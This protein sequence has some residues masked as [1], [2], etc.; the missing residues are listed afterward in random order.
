M[1]KQGEKYLKKIQNKLNPIQE[2]FNGILGSNPAMDA[3]LAADSK[4][5]DANVSRLNNNIAQYG[6]EYVDLKEKTEYYLNNASSN[7]NTEK[8]YNVFINKSL[9]QDKITGTNKLG[10]VKTDSVQDSLTNITEA[11]GFKAAYPANFK[12]YSA[13]ETAC[14]LWAADSSSPA[15][16]LNRDT[17]GV[18]QCYTGSGVAETRLEQYTIPKNL[19]T[20]AKGTESE[21]AG[22]LFANGQIGVWYGQN[23]I[24]WNTTRMKEITYLKKYNSSDYSDRAPLAQA[25][26]Q[27]WWGDSNPGTRRYGVWGY[28]LWPRDSKCWW[29]GNSDA[30]QP[31]SYFYYVYNAPG[32]MQAFAYV[33][34]PNN[35]VLK[36]NGQTIRIF[37]LLG[38][39]V[40]GSFAYVYLKK[41]K[42]VFEIS[43]PSGFPTSGFI[44]YWTQF[45][46]LRKILFRTGDAGW[47]VTT[48]PV[49]D[50][51]LIA[52]AP[53]NPSNP[54]GLQPV[55]AVPANYTICDPILGASLNKHSITANYGRNC[56]NI[57]NPPLNVRFVQFIPS[58]KTTDNWIQ[59]AQVV[60]N[61]VINGRV[62][63]I[64]NKG[65]IQ[66]SDT[67]G[68]GSSPRY[69]VD[70]NLAPRAFPGIHHSGRVSSASWGPYWQLDFGDEYPVT[71]IIYYN[72]SDC[73]SWRADGMTIRL[74]DMSANLLKVITLTGDL[75]QSFNITP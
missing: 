35:Q 63:N 5:T 67:Y 62:V 34:F 43:S 1:F 8:N 40:G 70:G 73:C 12:T 22:G 10:C 54:Y 55:N 9:N 24:E 47:G 28:N 51:R 26:S 37:T 39:V 38:S 45:P 52:D 56:S 30:T 31:T 36:I 16:A 75:Q 50:W 14:K 29:I 21:G 17:N 49:P 2:S 32:A 53:I 15:Y 41:G 48:T 27:G 72:R 74:Y 25:V 18:F 23:N 61:A 7:Y 58:T 59:I 60:V 3:T 46:D 42:N 68:R 69:P 71:Q 33:I 57:T 13:A 44:M 4:K 11:P 20:L 6:T 19:Y 65:T 66:Y 64:A